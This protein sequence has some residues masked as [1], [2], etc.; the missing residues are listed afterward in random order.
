MNTHDDLTEKDTAAEAVHGRIAEALTPLAV[1]AAR[2]PLLQQR[3]A[4]RIAQSA[5]RHR[6]LRTVRRDDAQ[7]QALTQG[8]R[9]CVL[10]DNG[11]TRSALVEF[12]PG[13][14]L[15]SHRHSAHEECIV[16]RGS[17]M[18]G[19]S[20]IGV[21]DYHIAPAGSRHVRIESQDGALAFLRGT[22]IGNTGA[23]LR[24]VAAAW[25]PGDGTRP[26]TVAAG[27]GGW[28]EI[29]AG[30]SIKPLWEMGDTASFLMRLDA[31]TRLPG[32]PHAFDEE[33][34]MLSGEAFIGDILLREGE[35]HLAP[36]GLMHGDAYS[37]IGALIFVHGDAAYVHL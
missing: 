19:D 5:A 2:A 11:A 34:L 9:A 20:T 22:S 35:Y 30:A 12:A 21:H 6:G 15:P 28:R 7:W 26:V 3:I 14:H 24:E 25:V 4:A 8:V 27:N 18:A 32:H 16:L 29:A 10:H 31:G 17:L 36:K 13:S 33:C 1:P 37:G 23:M